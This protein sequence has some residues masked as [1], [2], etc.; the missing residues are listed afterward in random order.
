[1]IYKK[2]GLSFYGCVILND[3][4]LWK[5]VLLFVIHAFS[6][7]YWFVAMYVILSD[8]NDEVLL[9]KRNRD[10]CKTISVREERQ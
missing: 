3:N 6:F 1:M 10:R 4:K 7:S 8:E 9:L 2:A 5:I